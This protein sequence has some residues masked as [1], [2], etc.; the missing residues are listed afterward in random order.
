[1]PENREKFPRTKIIAG[2]AVVNGMVF[3]NSGCR[4]WWGVL[5]N[6]MLEETN[7][8][9]SE[10]PAWLRRGGNDAGGENLA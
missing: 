1:M 7:L 6:V 8:Q 3:V 5:G 9:A 10:L 4:Q 2:S